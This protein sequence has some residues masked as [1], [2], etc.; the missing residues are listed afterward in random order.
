MPMGNGVLDR[1]TESSPGAVRSAERALEARYSAYVDEAQRLIQ[2]GMAAMSEGDTV[3]PRVSDI[4]RRAGLSNKAFYRHF[5]SKEELLLAVLEESMRQRAEDFEARI[6]EGLSPV[7]RV[8][9]WIWSVLDVAIDPER[10]AANRPLFVYQGR[11]LDSLGSSMSSVRGRMFETLEQA[12]RAGIESG[13]FSASIEPRCAV[14][15]IHYLSTGWVHGR[16]LARTV[17]SREEA[18]CIVEFALSGLKCSRT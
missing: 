15:A 16:V 3:D 1:E 9:S 14:D 17:P 12:I 13:D 7:E 10:A 2:A 6:D 5:K 11:L 8:R 4:V 18:E